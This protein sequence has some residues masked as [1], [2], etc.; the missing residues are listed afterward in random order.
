MNALLARI[1]SW[2][3][4]Q[5]STI[6]SQPQPTASQPDASSDVRI[7]A[8]WMGLLLIAFGVAMAGYVLFRIGEVV[9]DPRAIETQVDRWEFVIRG[10]TTDAF[11]QA[12]ETPERRTLNPA[13]LAQ[14]DD[15]EAE[16]SQPE[17]LE[18]IR[19]A[20]SEQTDEMARFIGRIG[21]KSARPAALFLIIVLLMLLVRI[22][23]A[24]IHA[25]IRMIY[26]TAGEKD[27]MKRIIDELTRQ[28]NHS[29]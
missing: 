19:A 25:G 2:K 26:L 28:R 21:S 24:I 20:Q 29:E 27:H 15:S 12:Y 22:I 4:K 7:F 14:S 17:G 8:A 6:P 1:Y 16:S 9:M 13:P 5:D 11:P 23:I 3:M 18:E 10:H